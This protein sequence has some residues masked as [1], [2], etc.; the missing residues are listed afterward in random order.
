MTQ[1]RTPEHLQ[2]QWSAAV[3][4]RTRELVAVGLSARVV[5]LT[6]EDEFSLFCS[7]ETLRRQ[8]RQHDIRWPSHAGRKVA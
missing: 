7:E 3:I 5:V 8:M 6:L 1:P 2:V 4:Q